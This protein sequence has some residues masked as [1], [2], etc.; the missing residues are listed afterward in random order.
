LPS[1]VPRLTSVSLNC[2]SAAVNGGNTSAQNASRVMEGSAA[3]GV[4]V[5]KGQI[6]N[7]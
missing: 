1:H 6:M 2:A 7:G 5:V 3:R 4:G